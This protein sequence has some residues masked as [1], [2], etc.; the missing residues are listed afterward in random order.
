MIMRLRE[1]FGVTL[2]YLMD[3]GDPG[4]VRSTHRGRWRWLAWL[5][6]GLIGVLLALVSQVSFQAG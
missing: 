6:V 1:L 4:M 3:G 2:D 5:S